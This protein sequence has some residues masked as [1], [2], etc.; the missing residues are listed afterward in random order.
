M[1]L[2]VTSWLEITTTA[3]SSQYTKL[4]LCDCRCPFRS[5]TLLRHRRMELQLI[6]NTKLIYNNLNDLEQHLMAWFCDDA[7]EQT[8]VTIREYFHRIYYYSHK[9][10]VTQW[11]NLKQRDAWVDWSRYLD[12]KMDLKERGYKEV[13]WIHLAQQWLLTISCENIAKTLP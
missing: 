3:W 6:L 8:S 7:Y 12:F 9:H 1:Y 4:F 13:D 11:Q 2:R 10:C 5:R